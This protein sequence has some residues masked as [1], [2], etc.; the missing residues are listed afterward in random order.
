MA[1]TIRLLLQLAGRVGRAPRSPSASPANRHHFSRA[2]GLCPRNTRKGA[3]KCKEPINVQDRQGPCR[4]QIL[5]DPRH[6]QN[7]RRDVKPRTRASAA[8]RAATPA[9]L[10]RTILLLDFRVLSRAYPVVGIE[11]EDRKIPRTAHRDR[12]GSAWIFCNVRARDE[13][14]ASA[15]VAV[16]DHRG[17]L[18]G[19]HG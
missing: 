7:S 15:I 1:R 3:K 6:R 2:I 4:G 14:R 10:I 12:G 13:Q 18:P 19:D 16:S 17:N 8:T 5:K 9:A 11:A